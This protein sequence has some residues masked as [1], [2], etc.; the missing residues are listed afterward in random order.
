MVAVMTGVGIAVGLLGPFGTYVSMSLLE[1]VLH[2]G[3]CFTLTGALAIEGS[4]RVA[5]QWFSGRW[6]LWAS[7][8]FDLAN[9][10]IAT[11]FV[12]LSLQAIAPQVMVYVDV[13]GL[14]LQNMLIFA[15]I[16]LTIVGVALWRDTRLNDIT[17]DPQANLISSDSVR[18]RLP[19]ALK[20]A[21]IFALSAEDHYL[22]VYTARGE[23]LVHLRLSEA[24]DGLA[25]FQIHRSH[26]ISGRALKDYDNRQVYLVNG[27]VFPVSRHR[28]REFEQW[29]NATGITP[30]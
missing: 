14:L 12:W 13:V 21:E 29:L 4:Y 30:A 23:A 2:F 9:I 25:G 3:L 24:I 5:R 8:C 1:R 22:R 7:L 27:S 28:R 18:T 26:W 16:R 17:P 15:L 6:P 20:G 11:V 19:F 10:P